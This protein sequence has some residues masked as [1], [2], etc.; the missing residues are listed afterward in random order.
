MCQPT[1]LVFA[2]FFARLLITVAVSLRDFRAGRE[3]ILRA[4]ATTALDRADFV[5][6]VM[7]HASCT[8]RMAC[9][10]STTGRS[11]SLFRIERWHMCDKNSDTSWGSAGSLFI[12]SCR[13][14]RDHS[15][16]LY[17]L[18]FSVDFATDLVKIL[19]R[20]LLA[21]LA[22]GDRFRSEVRAFQALRTSVRNECSD[23]VLHTTRI[24]IGLITT[25]I[26]HR[27]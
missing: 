10:A 8:Y 25:N 21:R 24:P 23:Q 27:C 22:R 9:C 2:N 16:H 5:G 13:A 1:S 4:N 12:P 15:R 17:A 14:K 6:F 20:N 11:V 7:S 18:P 19:N 26:T 3:R